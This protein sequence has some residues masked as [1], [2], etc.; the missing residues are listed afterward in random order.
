MSNLPREANS[1]DTF[2][3]DTQDK[4]VE[5]FSIGPAEAPPRP[6]PQPLD[7][8]ASLHPYSRAFYAA[9]VRAHPEWKPLARL[10]PTDNGYVPIL[11]GS[12]IA[13]RRS[14]RDFAAENVVL[15]RV[16]TGPEWQGNEYEGRHGA[17]QTAT[18]HRD[19]RSCRKL[20]ESSGLVVLLEFLD[21]SQQLLLVC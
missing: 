11:F 7:D 4:C 12:P 2:V 1:T 6:T 9:I 19:E 21:V 17:A 13:L 18:H 20:Y 16:T 5:G 14:A 3:L 15:R 10:I 8:P